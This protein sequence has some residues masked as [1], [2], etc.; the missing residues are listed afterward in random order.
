MSPVDVCVIICE[1]RRLWTHLFKLWLLRESYYIHGTPLHCKWSKV[2]LVWLEKLPF[3]KYAESVA[4][5]RPMGATFLIIV[6]ISVLI[7]LILLIV[8]IILFTSEYYF[9]FRLKKG[10]RLIRINKMHFDRL[11]T[12]L[13]SEHLK[14][15]QEH[16]CLQFGQP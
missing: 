14:C 8:I 4:H 2:K 5:D 16:V 11:T 7:I 10:C 13:S 3:R 1:Q 9:V 6:K 12:P 15:D